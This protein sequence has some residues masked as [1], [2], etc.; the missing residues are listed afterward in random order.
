MF[1]TST[2]TSAA[3][4]ALSVLVT[5]SIL[6]GIGSLAT[7]PAADSLLATRSVST[8]VVSAPSSSAPAVQS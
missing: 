6:G 3:A 1:N 2:R 5:V 8:Q 4:L 7:A